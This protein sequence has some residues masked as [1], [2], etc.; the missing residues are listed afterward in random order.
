MRECYGLNGSK[1]YSSVLR[2]HP[3][4]GP[5]VE[6]VVEDTVPGG[7]M[8]FGRRW[9]AGD[10]ITATT[11]TVGEHFRPSTCLLIYRNTIFHV[12]IL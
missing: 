7:L 3:A 12:S 2:P 6:G 4:N 11:H 10:S 8:V 5:G 9:Q 1:P